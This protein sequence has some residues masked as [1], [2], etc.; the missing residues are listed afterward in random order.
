MFFAGCTLGAV[1][2]LGLSPRTGGAGW[3]GALDLASG[4]G[5]RLRAVATAVFAAGI[6]LAVAG[7]GLAAT[8]RVSS[9]TGGIE[10]LALH[11][12]AS[13]KPIAYTPVCAD[14]SGGFLVCLHPAYR[15]YL[16]QALDSFGPVMAEVSGLPGAPVRA[17]EVPGLAVPS[18]VQQAFRDGIVTGSPPVYEFSM[19]GAIDQVPDPAQFRDGFRQD[20]V[21][22]VIV[23]P[24]GQLTASGV[25]SGMWAPRRSRPWR[26]GCSR[27][28]AR[29]PTP[30][31]TLTC[32]SARSSRRSRPPPPGSRRCPPPRGTPGW[33]PTWPR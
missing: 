1:G 30:R 11:D 10:V 22:A 26:T 2:L 17:V 18:V 5:A 21:H 29:S 12:S 8:A 13:D 28:S 6:A 19:D 20:I 3:R 9:V 32:S 27:R 23:G 24:V 15:S 14:A 33:P 16:S 31:A 4:G 7:F 25:S